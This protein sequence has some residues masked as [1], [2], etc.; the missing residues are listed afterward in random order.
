MR[1]TGTYLISLTLVISALA[2][3]GCGGSGKGAPTPPKQVLATFLRNLYKGD[4]QGACTL[5]TSQAQT[6]FT[7]VGKQIAELESLTKTKLPGIKTPIK[8]S[9]CTQTVI[10]FHALIQTQA[11]SIDEAISQVPHASLTQ[12]GSSAQI[13][14]PGQAPYEMILIGGRWL[15]NNVP[16]SS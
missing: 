11:S 12:K 5:M 9:D 7:L 10:L 2:L 16:T 14:I 4:S 6:E 1:R 13:L 8:V 15:L 3:A